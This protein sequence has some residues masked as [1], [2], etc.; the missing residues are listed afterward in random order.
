MG[1]N[2]KLDPSI[3]AKIS[4]P[5]SVLSA[6]DEELRDPL[7]GRA[8]FGKRSELVTTLLRK[9][10]HERGVKKDGVEIIKEHIFEG[11]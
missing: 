4:I 9:W 10:L 6:V 7:T 8:A 1:R 2:R 3:H 11:K 5:S